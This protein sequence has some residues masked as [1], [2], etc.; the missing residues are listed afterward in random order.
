V[1][2]IEN[3]SQKEHTRRLKPKPGL[4]GASAPT[5]LR[6]N[7]YLKVAIIAA[8]LSVATTMAH[9][10][11]IDYRQ[12]TKHIGDDRCVTG[13]VVAVNRGDSGA[14]F[15]NFCKDYQTCPFSV[16]VFADDLR[17]VG[18][19][20]KLDGKK[21][22]IHGHIQEYDGRP[23]IILKDIRQLRGEAAKIPPIPKDFDVRRRGNF[24]ARSISSSSK[25][26]TSRKKSPR[27]GPPDQPDP[28]LE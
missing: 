5:W 3:W 27:R 22:E 19:I 12:A 26:S 15:V 8:V 28:Q 24:S 23:E 10:G 6:P 14:Y 11:C 25:S 4:N 17:D 21:I 9:A 13:K 2:S 18:D 7:S 1:D 20:R 16:V